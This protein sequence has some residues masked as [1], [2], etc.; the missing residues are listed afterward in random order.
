MVVCMVVQVMAGGVVLVWR[1]C[2]VVVVHAR[3]TG[4]ARLSTI[5][6]RHCYGG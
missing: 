1:C 3:E 6:V 2:E 5:V 4:G